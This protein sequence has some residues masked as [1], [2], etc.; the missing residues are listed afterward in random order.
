MTVYRNE[1]TQTVIVIMF[2]G[3]KDI[4]MWVNCA[5]LKLNRINFVNSCNAEN[6][7]SQLKASAVGV[8]AC[9]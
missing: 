8:S 9:N 5:N 6:Q 4:L 2:I 7:R 1:N 3:V